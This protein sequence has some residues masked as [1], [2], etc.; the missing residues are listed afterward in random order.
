MT[1]MV[2]AIGETEPLTGAEPFTMT[3]APDSLPISP[4]STATFSR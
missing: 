3:S 4:I 2:R 1:E